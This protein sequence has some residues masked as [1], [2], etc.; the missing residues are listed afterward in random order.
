MEGHMLD[1]CLLWKDCVWLRIEGGKGCGS[2]GGGKGVARLGEKLQSTINNSHTRLTAQGGKGAAERENEMEG[3]TRRPESPVGQRHAHGVPLDLGAAQGQP[4]GPTS[5]GQR[6]VR[7]A[8]KSHRARGSRHPKGRGVRA[9]RGRHG[10]RR[11]L[12]GAHQDT[13][14]IR[15][16]LQAVP[17]P[18]PPGR[19][20]REESSSP[21]CALIVCWKTRFHG[22]DGL[23]RASQ[24]VCL[25]VV[26]R[27]VYVA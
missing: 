9:E 11:S 20:P 8:L 4:R 6:H 24:P 7:R 10:A 3:V 19:G 15:G 25:R 5:R 18:S 27:A 21:I 22:C 23:Y 16:E 26:C 14:C 17:P 2:P 1:C 12:A 13:T